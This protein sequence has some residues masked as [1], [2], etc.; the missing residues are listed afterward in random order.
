LIP[1]AAGVAG[2][3]ILGAG[4]AALAA[5]NQPGSLAQKIAA[6]FHLDAGKV[7]TVIDQQHADRQAQREQKYEE[8]LNAAVTSGQL[9]PSQKDA[10]LA[11][12]NK[13]EDEL[14][15]AAGLSRTD[16]RALLQKVRAEATAW[17]QQN[18]LP[19]HW[20]AIGRGGASGRHLHPMA[21]PAASPNPSPS[22]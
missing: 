9:T 20:L 10:V 21:P 8:K 12:H 4:T 18:H 13:L 14:K 1:V 7:Q 3:A 22:A 15:G 19:A 2:V 5:G 11:E 6:T 16:R 17:S